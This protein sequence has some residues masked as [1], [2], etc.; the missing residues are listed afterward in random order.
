MRPK[1]GTLSPT[2]TRLKSPLSLAIVALSGLADL[3]VH[4]TATGLGAG[5]ALGGVE[6]A[7]GAL[8]VVVFVGDFIGSTM[9]EL[10]DFAD[11]SS[12]V[13]CAN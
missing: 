11:F 9:V 4:L 12:F 8:E 10:L 6:V 2:S 5:L 3:S 7:L 13:S 1:P